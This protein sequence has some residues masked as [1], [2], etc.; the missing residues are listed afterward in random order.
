MFVSFGSIAAAKAGQYASKFMG[1]IEWIVGKSDVFADIARSFA[2]VTLPIKATTK[3]IKTKTGANFTRLVPGGGLA[4]HEAKTVGGNLIKGGHTITKH[5]GKTEA[6]LAS[7]LATQT[8]L[9]FASS[10]TDRMIAEETLSDVLKINQAT[11][12]SFVS[13]SGGQKMNLPVYT[14]TR[15]VGIVL[16]RGATNAVPVQTVTVAIQKNPSRPLGYYIL[17]TLLN[18]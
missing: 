4:A 15:Q 5:I 8:H 6:D 9:N 7:R 3:L 10:F 13:G 17:T 12:S 18:P 2:V 11:I 16:A 1:L 14:P